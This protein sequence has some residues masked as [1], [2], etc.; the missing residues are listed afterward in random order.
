[1]RCLMCGYKET[2]II[3]LT[4]V[5]G[6]DENPLI[7]E[8]IPTI[9]CPKCGEM[10]WSAKTAKEIEKYIE[11]HKQNLVSETVKFNPSIFA[12]DSKQ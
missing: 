5:Y 9:Y 10:Y 2:Y 8:N 1:M 11:E 4:R 7:L 12:I 6:D 3:N